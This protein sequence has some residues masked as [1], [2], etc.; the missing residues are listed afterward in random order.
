VGNVFFDL[1]D[2][3]QKPLTFSHLLQMEGQMSP[4]IIIL[5]GQLNASVLTTEAKMGDQVGGI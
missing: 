1:T 5:P 3:C 2:L 4:T